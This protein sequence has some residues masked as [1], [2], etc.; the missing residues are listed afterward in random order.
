VDEKP[1]DGK[2]ANNHGRGVTAAVLHGELA[3]LAE[4]KKIEFPYENGRSLGQR[5]SNAE[6]NLRTIIDITITKDNHKKHKLY[7]FKPLPNG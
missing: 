7:T 2:G 1:P 3:A 5:L 4:R 6:P